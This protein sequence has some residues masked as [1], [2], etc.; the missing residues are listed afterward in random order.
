MAPSVDRQGYWGR[1]TSTLDWC[2]ENYAVSFYIAEFWNTMSNLIMIVPPLYG[3]LQT[4][5]DGLETRY[6]FAF[7]GLAAVGIGSWCF[8]MTLQYEMQLLDEL[9]MIYSC[10]VFV[11]CLYE[12]FKQE[13]SINYIPIVVL[14]GF[15]I[16]VTVVYL[17][18]KEPVFHQVMYGILVG[19]LVLRSV[20]IVTWVYPWHRSL[21]YASLAIFFL[22][23]VFWNVD[24][25]LCDT[26]RASRQNLPP[27]IG[28][29]T[30]F[31]AW[32]HILTGLGSHL[33]ILLSLQT[34]ATY[35]R[36]RP[37][38]KF[39]CSVWPMVHTEPRRRS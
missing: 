14:A 17:Q 7:L 19:C 33:H 26:L 39:L 38:V 4:L 10:C 2:E 20:Y 18:W 12:C 24:N 36:R 32:W 31:H 8:H 13:N 22:G 1:P 9:P 23:F 6:V 27:L 21:C 35:L 15:S 34:R 37:Q 29:V 11:Y 3:A 5:K 28:A 25:L 16:A 30:Q